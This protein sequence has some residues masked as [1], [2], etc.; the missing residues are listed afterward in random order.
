MDL[1]KKNR[2]MAADVRKSLV[3]IKTNS[4]SELWQFERLRKEAASH[5]ETLI[6]VCSILTK[7]HDLRELR[8]HVFF[9]YSIYQH[10]FN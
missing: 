1:S 4:C 8:V 3:R 7:R 9:P 6:A 5:Q 10:H 2:L